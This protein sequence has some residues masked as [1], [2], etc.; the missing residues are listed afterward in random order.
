M[1]IS[2][3]TVPQK[4]NKKRLE[5]LIGKA[6]RQLPATVRKRD[7]GLAHFDI[8][9]IETAITKC[10]EA[11]EP[12][13]RTPVSDVTAMAVRAMAA[14]WNPNTLPSVEEVQDVVE[15]ALQSTGEYA[16]AKNYILYRR[17]HS[18]DRDGRQVPQDVREAFAKSATFFPTQAQ[19]FMFYD[20]YSRYNND[21]QRRETWVET[22]ERATAFL[23]ELAEKQKPG[24][25]PVEESN[26]IYD[27]ILNM[28]AMPSMRLLATAGDYAR[29][30]NIAV[31]NCSYIPVKDIEAFCEALLIS[32]SGCGVGFSVEREYV[33]QFP[34]VKRQKRTVSGTVPT[35]LVEDSTEGWIE[36]VRL[37]LTTWWNG[38]DVNFDFSL[39]RRAGLPL[40]GK[41]GRASGPEPLSNMLVF[42]RATVLSRQGSFIR[43]VDGHDMMCAV[44][45]AAVQG[46][47]RRT[48]MLSL[49]DWDDLEM[50]NC[51]N[52]PW[53]SW[54]KIR[55][56]ANNSA[57]WPETLTQAD[58][59][60]QMLDMDKG[61]RGEPGIFS[62]ENAIRTRPKRRKKARFGT[63]PCGEINLRPYQFCNLSIAVARADDTIETLKEKVEVATLIGTLQSLATDFPGL[64]PEWKQNCEEERLLGVDITGQMD[65]PVVRDAAVMRELRDHAV[66]VNAKWA[67]IFG[68]PQSASVTCDKPGGNSSQ[69]LDVANGIH[70]RHASFLNRNMR[71]SA[72]SPVYKALKA[73]G[74]PMSP[75]NEQTV[76]TATT[77]VIHFPMKSPAGSVLRRDL[78]AI[79]QLEYWKMA[80]TN[81]TEHNPSCTV[82]YDPDELVEVIS[83]LWENKDYVGGLSFLPKDDA[84]YLQMP[85]EEVTEDEYLR[86]VE[87]FPQ[88]D[89]SKIY[90]YELA[91]MTT[92]TAE[93]ACLA[94][95]CEV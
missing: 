2:P 12:Q 85:Y 74:V 28:Q 42:L 39:V 48:A 50:R 23:V 55:E 4:L 52:G 40:L 57:V 49:F 70:G 95:N 18:D 27:F 17:D 61:Q 51:K 9:R 62:R 43:T 10:F 73:A 41:G 37:G 93:L 89:F 29:S 33:E 11:T 58:L 87:T 94:G 76:E 15:Y 86:R 35:H 63:N 32:M 64:R 75:E 83:W 45:E 82:S 78:T 30:Q 20:K 90:T 92:A 91:D 6:G 46:G 71:V 67:E 68:I 80:K 66:E 65:C 56:N 8:E 84:Q 3:D 72:H 69:L 22:V 34:R 25:L 88:I 16:A 31:Y 47:V 79:D 53:G 7:G 5:F 24:S 54:P 19:Q 77:W 36:A 38:E 60:Q 81:W 59:I 1:T 14:R 26:R 13:P 44:G 21:L